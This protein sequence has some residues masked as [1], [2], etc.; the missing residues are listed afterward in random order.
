[1]RAP[2]ISLFP[3]VIGGPYEGSKHFIVSKG[4]R[5]DL[6]KGSKHFIVFQGLYCLEPRTL[7][8]GSKHFIVSKGY[9][10]TRIPNRVIG[11]V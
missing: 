5:K 1:M 11:P 10:R 4:Y 9:R 7:Y 8:E 6:Y 2:N 3:R